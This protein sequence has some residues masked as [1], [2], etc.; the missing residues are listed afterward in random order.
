MLV[1]GADLT[2]VAGCGLVLQAMAA[3][4]KAIGFEGRAKHND[5]AKNNK[6][7]SKDLFGLTF[8]A[9]N[10]NIVRDVRW[11]RS[12]ETL[13]EDPF[14]TA[15]LA[16]PLIRG[17]QSNASYGSSYPLVSA[18][19]KHFFAYNLES[20]FAAGGTDGQYRL[21]ANVNVSETDLVQTYFPAFDA[22]VKE[23]EVRSVMCSCEC[24]ARL[25][26]TDITR[27]PPL[28][29]LSTFPGPTLVVTRGVPSM[30]PYQSFSG[31]FRYAVV[32][33]SQLR[34]QRA[35]PQL[36]GG[37]L[38]PPSLATI[39]SQ[40]RRRKKALSAQHRYTFDSRVH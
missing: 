22:A 14:L 20:N 1:S 2:P 33:G 23:A 19:A 10:I 4:G 21:R 8:F 32:V 7:Q 3:V 36:L 16:V 13:G 24:A 11:G 39:S 28:H 9:P 34:P 40:K 29:S 5:Y 31:G 17:M 37:P 6:G 26:P 12:Q 30:P 18:T 38:A 15:T 35:S 25:A 27:V